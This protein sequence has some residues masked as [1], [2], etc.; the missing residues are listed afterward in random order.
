[1]TPE[2]RRLTQ[3]AE[4]IAPDLEF[5]ETE[6]ESEAEEFE[7]GRMQAFLQDRR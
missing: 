4:R 7:A 5:E 2:E 6:E 1:V 3:E